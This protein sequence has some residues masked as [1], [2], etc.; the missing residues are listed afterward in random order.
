MKRARLTTM[1]RTVVTIM[2]VIEGEVSSVSHPSSIM[3]LPD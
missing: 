2:L 3:Y 1:G